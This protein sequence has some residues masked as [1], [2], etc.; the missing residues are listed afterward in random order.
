MTR[1]QTRRAYSPCGLPGPEKLALNLCALLLRLGLAGELTPGVLERFATTA[2]PSTDRKRVCAASCDAA[3][4][5]AHALAIIAAA[6][7]LVS[8]CI[9]PGPA[10]P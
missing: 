4:R 10:A 2:F 9:P 1:K 6:V 5:L 3:Y 8:S 7:R